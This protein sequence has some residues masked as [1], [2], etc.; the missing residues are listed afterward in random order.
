MC[1]AGVDS[2]LLCFAKP[3]S[4]THFWKTD[5]KMK[6]RPNLQENWCY[7]SPLHKWHAN[8]IIKDFAWSPN[9]RCQYQ[10]RFTCHCNFVNDMFFCGDCFLDSR[11][12]RAITL[13]R[14]DVDWFESQRFCFSKCHFYWTVLW[15]NICS[16][17]EV[18]LKKGSVL[19]VLGVHAELDKQRL[20]VN[21]LVV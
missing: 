7:I 20:I 3:G 13:A 18:E 5:V 14:Q 10:I 6:L 12:R 2:A 21:R 16:K 4:Q 17:M 19:Q 1:S 8:E 11:Y 15:P 9:I